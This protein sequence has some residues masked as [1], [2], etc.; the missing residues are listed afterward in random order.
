MAEA[1]DHSLKSSFKAE[2]AVRS[3][4]YVISETDCKLIKSYHE[5][6]EPLIADAVNARFESIRQIPNYQQTLTKFGTVLG[7][8]TAQHFRQLGKCSFGDDYVSSLFDVVEVQIASGFGIG[9]HLGL[10]PVLANLYWR[11]VEKSHR[12]SRRSQ[13]RSLQAITMLLYFDS[14]NVSALHNRKLASRVQERSDYLQSASASF[15]DAI[16]KIRSSLTTAAELVVATAGRAIDVTQ[17]A[18]SEANLTIDAWTQATGAI[19]AMSQSADGISHS[20]GMI[21]EQTTHSREAARDALKIAF[22]AENAIGSLLEMT[23]TIRSVTELIQTVSRRTHLIALN[24][25]IEA[26]RAGE[27]GRGFAVV[28]AEVKQLSAQI[29]EATQQIEAQLI[30]IHESTLSCHAGIEH[31]SGAVR[32]MENI[33]EAIANMVNEHDSA[34][35]EIKRQAHETAAMTETVQKSERTINSVFGSLADAAKELDAVARALA[36]HSDELNHE[37]NKFIVAVK[38]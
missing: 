8:V 28:A 7:N 18:G 34:A 33:A 16:A 32:G 24:A 14:A 10:G 36:S 27:S 38:I 15:L 37:A 26:A 31:V 4:F 21:C 3:Q 19:S 35:S 20:I 5:M 9:A 13:M 17:R 12:F 23:L 6:I 11:V 22:D 30:R 2:I 25:T 1:G 29:T